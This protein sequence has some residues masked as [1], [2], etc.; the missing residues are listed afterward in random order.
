MALEIGK[1]RFVW[2]GFISAFI[3]CIL[4]LLNGEYFS[5]QEHYIQ[6]I[7][8]NL[9]H[10]LQLAEVE[11]DLVQQIL[12]DEP[13]KQFSKLPTDLNNQYFIFRN[14][15]IW[16]WSDYHFVP[17]YESISGRFSYHFL[18]LQ[19]GQFVAI[20]R[21]LVKGSDKKLLEIVS[22]IPLTRPPEQSPDGNRYN[23]QI[24]SSPDFSLSNPV[25]G[26]EGTVYV[27]DN[28]P[29]FK[30][31]L[32]KGYMNGPNHYKLFTA[33]F[34]FLAVVFWLISLLKISYS[35]LLNRKPKKA[36]GLLAGGLILLRALMLW[37][38]FPYSFYPFPLFDSR[39]YASSFVNP[40][41]GDFLI[42]TLFYFILAILLLRFWQIYR[43][44]IRG[45]LIR[46]QGKTGLVIAVAVMHFLL[47]LVHYM[48]LHELVF[49]AQYSLDITN[50]PGVDVFKLVSWLIFS[51]VTFVFVLLNYILSIC[52]HD[53]FKSRSNGLKWYSV[54][55][56]LVILL[57]IWL[58]VLRFV[59]VI[60]VLYF[61]AFLLVQRKNIVR[62]YNY[63]LFVYIFCS[64]IIS[65]FAGSLAIYN[66]YKQNRLMVK[67]RF[68]NQI[69][70]EHD[71]IGEY[72]LSEAVAKIKED[73][74][75]KSRFFS[76]LFSKEG[77][78]Q[79]IRRQYLT[80]Y[81][82]KYGADILLFNVD[83][84]VI[85]HPKR[86]L[87]FHTL[88]NLASELGSK[89][90]YKGLYLL[91]DKSPA[92]PGKKYQ[93]FIP[94]MQG[95]RPL[96]YIMINLELKRY[97]SYTIYPELYF[98]Q[99]LQDTKSNGLNYAVFK[100]G[101]L[102]YNA[103]E[104]DYVHQ[105]PSDFLE[106]EVL[107]E[108]GIE[109][110]GY[111]HFGVEDQKGQVVVV[112]DESE[113]SYFIVSNFSFLFLL[114]IFWVTLGVV[115][116][117][118]SFG[119]SIRRLDFTTK[120][121]LVLNS[122]V[123]LP[124]FIV[125]ATT[126]SLINTSFK[127]S[128]EEQY[129]NKAESISRTLAEVLEERRID[130][131]KE[132]EE[133]SNQ[134]AVLSRYAEVDIHLFNT[135]GLLLATNQPV[136][137][138]QNYLAPYINPLAFAEIKEQNSRQLIL[139]ET[140]NNLQ[141]KSAY[142][143]VRSSR[144]GAL[145]G[146]LSLPFFESGYELEQQLSA[147]FSNIVNIFAWLF[148][149]FFGLLYLLSRELTEPLRYIAQKM[150]QVSLS[151][152]NEP[153]QWT[154][155]DEIGKLV[156]EYNSMLANLQESKEAL[157]RSEKESAWR[158]MAKQ[159]AH[160]IKNPLTPMKL[161]LQHMNRMLKGKLQGNGEEEKVEKTVRSLLD[162][163][164]TLSDIATSFS[165]FAKMPVPKSERFD[166]ARVLKGVLSLYSNQEYE[167]HADIEEG[168]FWVL[169]DEQMMQRTF[170]NLILNG[171]QAV[172]AGRE[173]EIGISLQQYDKGRVLIE[174]SDNGE[175]IDPSIR[176]KVFVPNFSTKYTGSGLGLAIA[177]R[178]I[179]HAGGRIWFETESGKGTSF[180]IELPLIQ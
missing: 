84:S 167:I 110:D 20:K 6:E 75:I 99:R 13:E 19:E 171:I 118:A 92:S 70:T 25:K 79:K 176:D 107:Y 82:D 38:G 43:R 55:A 81:F 90:D 152:Q 111:H 108:K 114:C 105:L 166:I 37:I 120:I 151:G 95:E 139:N 22:F 39:Y 63:Q 117:L 15:S 142:M 157:S 45:W 8:E 23:Q 135:K 89:T 125:S 77:V 172:P 4:F 74:Y 52:L 180:Y 32:G 155:D 46:Q 64:S 147:V 149:G 53:L 123:F 41:L 24:F 62:P 93:Q 133:I 30:I 154:T 106:K 59:A 2:L 10:Q 124:L 115:G 159:V 178:G 50:N 27:K 80:R 129:F 97:L 150:K 34:L 121:Q 130:T 16:Y 17:S 54:V 94:V 65:A 49:H 9:S 1:Y 177:K 113:P 132:K 48:V 103:G 100:N 85:N 101:K 173:A 31:S 162:Q 58:P 145:L 175:G 68:A 146:I 60:G 67:E 61:L 169:G 78:E 83:G 158:E 73:P 119:F 98:G 29:L 26:E 88:Q 40:S 86:Y 134:L 87:N 136:I 112:S 7:E 104:F 140:V 72:L 14:G 165:A 141:Y 148:I 12:S 179:E 128:T 76:P 91:N 56:L 109:V 170:N 18:D 96:G 164:D 3:A 44:S 138:Q 163:I 131:P 153:L 66:Y 69:L 42:N 137:Y 127:K 21:K 102:E 126:L 5:Q 35:F 156:R 144:T 47:L 122:A 36:F 168:E 116:Y 51:I 28:I 161:S 11:L 33:L 160:E 57:S 71:L 174:I 143:A